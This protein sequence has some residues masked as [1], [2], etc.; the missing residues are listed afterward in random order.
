MLHESEY[1]YFVCIT[2]FVSCE[3]LT[4]NVL[5]NGHYFTDDI[6]NYYNITNLLSYD[7]DLLKL[8]SI[9]HIKSS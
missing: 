1:M 2:V 8:S 5:T 3:S 4:H 7:I 9:G 6:I